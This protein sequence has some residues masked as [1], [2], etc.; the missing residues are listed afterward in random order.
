MMSLSQSSAEDRPIVH[1]LERVH[2]LK[3]GHLQDVS[4]PG[5]DPPMHGDGC[6][7]TI[8]ISKSPGPEQSMSSSHPA[9]SHTWPAAALGAGLAQQRLP[10]V[11]V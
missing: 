6:S 8:S 3:N 2:S 11:G 9:S 4:S 7:S 5:C 1:P 10:S